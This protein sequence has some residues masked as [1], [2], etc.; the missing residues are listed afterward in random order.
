MPKDDFMSYI[1]RKVGPEGSVTQCCCACCGAVSEH[2]VGCCIVT[3][4]YGEDPEI[5][6]AF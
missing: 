2:G 6:I 4:R 5:C 1:M 3:V